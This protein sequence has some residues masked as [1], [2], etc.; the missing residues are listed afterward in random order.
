MYL[1]R[2][3]DLKI[4]STVSKKNIYQISMGKYK[5]LNDQCC[6]MK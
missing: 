4:N 1:I 5:K 6:G 3:L 2:K